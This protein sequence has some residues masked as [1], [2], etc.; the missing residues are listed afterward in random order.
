MQETPLINWLIR[1][2]HPLE[3]CFCHYSINREVARRQELIKPRPVAVSVDAGSA[4]QQH[5][6]IRRGRAH[7]QHLGRAERH[8]PHSTPWEGV[9]A[10]W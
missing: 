2:Q 7:H 4:L 3:D 8:N 5:Q 6:V 1:M 10:A 9:D